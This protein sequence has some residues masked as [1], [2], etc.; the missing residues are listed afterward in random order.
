MFNLLAMFATLLVLQ[1]PQPPLDQE[2]KSSFSGNSSVEMS[3]KVTKV[4]DNYVY[5][6][7]IK[8]KGKTS[9]KVKWD[10]VSQ[11]MYN[12]NI[13]DLMFDL[14]PDENVVC[15][16]EHPDP[17]VQINGKVTSFYLTTN[18]KVEK[19]VKNTP[20][21]P[22]GMKIEIS[23]KTLYNSESGLGYGALPKSFIYPTF[24][25]R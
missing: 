7:S 25:G 21:L 8:N 6:Y 11:A 12:G 10:I 22:K 20:E 14:E 1:P 2:L 5:M 16:L 19:L 15:T 13:I 18:D 24:K 23:K 17:P 4:G 9:I 3:C